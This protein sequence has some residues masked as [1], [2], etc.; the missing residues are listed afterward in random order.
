VSGEPPA[1]M[2]VDPASLAAVATASSDAEADFVANILTA[3]GVPH[4]RQARPAA[5]GARKEIDILVPLEA[6]AKARRLLRLVPDF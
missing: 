4:Y 3:E 6:Q 1:A 2:P 5:G